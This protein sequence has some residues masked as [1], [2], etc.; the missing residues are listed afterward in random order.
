MRIGIELDDVLRDFSS[1]FA[2]VVA[3][4]RNRKIMA[5][6][7]M[8][9]DETDNYG[10]LLPNEAENDKL[11]SELR[12]EE[13]DEK[14]FTSSDIFKIDLEKTPLDTYDFLEFLGRFPEIV[15][16][17]S[18]DDLNLFMYSKAALEIFGHADLTEGKNHRDNIMVRFN[19]FL[20]EIADE[21]EHEIS[22]VSREAMNSIPASMFFLSKTLCKAQKYNFV[23]KFEQEW[24]D[25]DVLI[26]ASPRVLKAKP[27]GKISIKIERPYNKDVD[28]D[29][30][31]DSLIP[32][33]EDEEL[34][35]AILNGEEITKTEK[36][37]E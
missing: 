18:I 11:L 22:I 5:A 37:E 4:Y 1:Q 19:K 6:Y 16:F 23:T 10:N 13:F 3:K 2:Y 27:E 31:L 29:Y 21:E 8:H 36:E 35:E 25:V 28:A 17:Q 9:G 24:D 33:M 34:R 20:I 7:T 14:T 12:E 32:F 26:T 30:T 15:N